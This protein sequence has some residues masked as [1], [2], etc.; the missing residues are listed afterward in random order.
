MKNFKKQ[1]IEN[2]DKNNIDI[3]ESTN[4]LLDQIKK[5][6][7][8]SIQF[9]SAKKQISLNLSLMK[10]LSGLFESAMKRWN[11]NAEELDRLVDKLELIHQS[12]GDNNNS[13]IKSRCNKFFINQ[14]GKL[15]RS[16][17]Y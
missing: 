3:I 5:L 12:Y 10:G 16:N 7:F 9:Q 14:D 11:E 2:I 8:D 15:E 6:K 1:I 4:N 13:I 17:Q